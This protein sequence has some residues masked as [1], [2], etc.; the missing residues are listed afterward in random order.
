MCHAPRPRIRCARLSHASPWFPF[1]AFV[2]VTHTAAAAAIQAWVHRYHSPTNGPAAPAAVTFDHA[3]DVIVTGSSYNGTANDFYTAKYS[4]VDGTLLWERYY[5]GPTNNY[6]M[7]AAVA[8]D[9]EGN[10]V[11]TGVSNQHRSP[12]SNEPSYDD[13]YTVKYAALDGAVLW[14]KTY[15]GPAN[16]QDYPADLTLDSSG[17]AIVV[18][19]SRSTNAGISDFYVVKYSATNGTILWEQRPRPAYAYTA[20]S[21]ALDTEDNVIMTGVSTGSLY[22]AK[23]ASTN[24]A[25]SWERY[26]PKTYSGSVAVERNGNVAVTCTLPVTLDQSTDDIYTAKYA[27]ADGA[28]LWQIQYNSPTNHDDRARDVAVD[29]DGNV[30]VTGYSFGHGGPGYNFYTAKRSATNGAVIWERTYTGSGPGEDDVTAAHRLDESGNVIV[31]G[32]TH[33]AAGYDFYTAKYA[34]ATGAILWEHYYNGPA[35]SL[36][37]IHN[38]H[39]LA[40]GPFGMFAVTGSSG[41]E[42]A[43]V[44]YREHLPPLSLEKAAHGVRLR[45]P[46]SAGRSYQLQSAPTAHGPWSTNATF[47]PLT[48]G[49]LEY[50]ETNAPASAAFYRTST[51]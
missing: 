32:T 28:V 31:T 35:N 20:L 6:D 51:P 25:V 15:D 47:N 14:E 1:L 37:S 3:G 27:A 18:G 41:G 29:A 21:A 43:T 2:I 5:N 42:F 9:A 8:T 50:L 33:L 45:F 11:V 46:V 23:L 48:N 34:A 12:P 4:G 22:T 10:V 17:N 26:G 16:D 13:F 38:S 30:I 24:G 19:V 49:V 40:V 44:L 39:G 36:D 7:P